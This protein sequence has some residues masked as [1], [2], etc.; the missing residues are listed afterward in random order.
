MLADTQAMPA[1]R[2]DDSL[3]AVWVPAA[4][5]QAS[6][7]DSRL[8]AWI[9]G[10]L[11]PNR[12]PVQASIKTIRIVCTDTRAIVYAAPEQLSEAMDALARFT[13]AARG[14]RA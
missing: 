5:S 11:A 7:L 3:L 13:L 4:A 8:N 2:Q 10:D 9:R 12:A 6:D 14:F 1:G